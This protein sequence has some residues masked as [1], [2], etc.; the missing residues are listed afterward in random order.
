MTI[1]ARAV[2]VN[3]EPSSSGFWHSVS[4]RFPQD[5][6]SVGNSLSFSEVLFG[7]WKRHFPLFCQLRKCFLGS[8][9]AHKT[10]TQKC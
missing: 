4:V 8:H 7:G 1:T 6:S 2:S 3:Q 9:C 5:E 10:T